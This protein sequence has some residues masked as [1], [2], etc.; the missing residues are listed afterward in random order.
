MPLIERFVVLLYSRIS[1]ALT[2]NEARQELFSKKSRDI[3]NIP[4]T[5]AALLQ[6]TKRRLIIRL[7]MSG[8]VLWSLKH[9]FQARKNSTG[10]E[11]KVNG[12]QCGQFCN[13]WKNHVMS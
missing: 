12:S 4:P 8:E 2:V 9:R 6:C 3:K 5:Q 7:D 13:K 11:K 10:E 1:T